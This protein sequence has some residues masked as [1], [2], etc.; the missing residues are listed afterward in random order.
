MI[1]RDINS[2]SNMASQ[3]DPDRDSDP[4]LVPDEAAAHQT[5][6]PA[7]DYDDDVGGLSDGEAHISVRTLSR[8]RAL[9][10]AKK[11]TF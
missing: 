10:G 6:D 8:P 9:H 4:A 7:D 2:A 11:R 3:S 5:D 1:P